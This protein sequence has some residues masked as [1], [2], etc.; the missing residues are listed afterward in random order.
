MQRRKTTF[1]GKIVYCIVILLKTIHSWWQRPWWEH[2]RTTGDSRTTRHARYNHPRREEPTRRHSTRREDPRR[3]N[4]GREHTSSRRKD[5]RRKN[6]RREHTGRKHTSSRN[7]HTR[8]LLR[9]HVT[10]PR[11]KVVHLGGEVAHGLDEVG[12][13]KVDHAV[14]PGKLEGNVGTDVLVASVEAGGEAVRAAD[15]KFGFDKE[16]EELFGEFL[17]LQAVREEEGGGRR[18]RKEE[19]GGRRGEGRGGG[20]G[21]GREKVEDVGL[22]QGE[23]QKKNSE[24]QNPTVFYRQ[25]KTK[26]TDTGKKFRQPS[27]CA[28][29]G[30]DE[31]QGDGTRRTREGR[32]RDE[33]GTRE[34]RGGGRE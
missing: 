25:H 11:M 13:D 24:F 15:F 8:N 28:K 27:E 16:A 33:G 7:R 9:S 18:G 5:T 26:S 12:E 19:E 23:F 3:E 20:R 6:P 29:K 34:G 17:V 14:P 32:G 22:Y 4:P 30:W 21:G 1:S 10:R 31:G 2:T